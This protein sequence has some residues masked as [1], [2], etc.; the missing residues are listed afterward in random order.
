MSSTS[1]SINAAPLSSRRLFLRRAAVISAASTGGH[2][3]A[4]CSSSSNSSPLPTST[5]P[6]TTSTVGNLTADH[7]ENRILIIINLE[8]GNDGLSMVVPAGSSTYHDL[9][10]NLAIEDVLD[11]DTRLGLNPRLT[12]INDLGVTIVEGVGPTSADMS[13]F[14][15][16]ARWE[17]GDVD[18]TASLRTGFG[19]RLSDVLARSQ[20]QSPVT[21]ISLAG[22]TPF[23]YGQDAPAVSLY[24]LDD[25]WMLR[26]SE[27]DEL[28]A[29]QRSLASFG[30]GL[31]AD[32]Y[33][34][35][36]DLG[37]RLG[38]LDDSDEEQSIDW[39]HPMLSEGGSLGQ[40][41][42]LAGD[43][44]SAELGTRVM[45]AQLD[46]FDTHEGHEWRHEDLMGQLDAAVAGFYER[47]QAMG[48]ADRV[49]LATISEFGR[50]VRENDGGLDHG[51]AS[52]MLV[53]GPIQPQIL[54]QPSDLDDLDENGNLRVTTGLDTYLGSL[55]QEWLGIEASSVLPNTPDL[56]GLV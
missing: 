35:L 8:G 52:S 38:R 46:G 29:F 53:L 47:A 5:T 50:R 31:V 28:A 41:L 30:D 26:P 2:L 44:I 55:A 40:Q 4:A 17:Q 1:L 27:W 49:V 25:M 22:Q 45:Y 6:T 54:G 7:V 32:S 24:G 33:D 37:E 19:G 43:L 48:F 39:D 21:G 51:S 16:A 14:A 12:K 42:W 36:L 9:R 11:I 18:G 10:P 15:M 23:M 3:L 56:L 13:H 34:Q 20:G